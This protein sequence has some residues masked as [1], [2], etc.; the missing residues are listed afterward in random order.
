VM[1]EMQAPL[2]T[3][4]AANYSD[5]DRI[6][7]FQIKMA[8]ETE[9]I[10]LDPLTCRS[11]VQAVFA[12]PSLGTYHVCARGTGIVGSLLITPEWSDWRNGL[13][14]WIQSVYIEPELR[15]QGYFAKFY[16]YIKNLAESDSI[17]RGIRLYVD[18]SNVPAQTVYS[19]VGM[20][21]DHYRLYEWMKS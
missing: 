14:W 20:N 9:K 10:R 2:P 8:W 11:G 7:D 4:R 15:R 16:A 13:I 5:A 17:V 12:C 6:V 21:G 3:Y 1:I 18:R 19:K